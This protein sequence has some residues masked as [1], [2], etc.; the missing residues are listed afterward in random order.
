MNLR[1]LSGFFAWPTL[2]GGPERE[3][4]EEEDKEEG[5]EEQNKKKTNNSLIRRSEENAKQIIRARVGGVGA[6]GHGLC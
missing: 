6:R 4:E 3:E 2:F 5:G 1:G